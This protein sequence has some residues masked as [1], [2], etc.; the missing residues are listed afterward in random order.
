MFKERQF[1]FHVEGIRN[2]LVFSSDCTKSLLPVIPNGTHHFFWKSVSE[3]QIINFT[4]PKIGI[5]CF[6]MKHTALRRKSKYWLTWNRDNVFEWNNMSTCRLLF[7]WAST[8][9]IQLSL[10]QSRLHHRLIEMQLVL[11]M[12]QPKNLTCHL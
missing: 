12:I 3:N 4:W 2:T 7:Q 5:C 8:V 9:Q 1:Q 11:V 10:V 6:F